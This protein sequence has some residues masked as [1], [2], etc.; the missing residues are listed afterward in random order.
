MAIFRQN[1]DGSVSTVRERDGAEVE[2]VGGSAGSS[3]TNA[4]SYLG[5]ATLAFNVG[6]GTDT[7][8]GLLSWQNSLGYDVI[9]QAFALDVLTIATSACTA[10]FGHSTTS[11][12]SVGQLI[13]G[14]DV[15]SSTGVFNSASAGPVKVPSLD[16]ITGSVGGGT[17]SGLVARAYFT[18]IPA[19][20]AGTA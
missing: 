17:S 14:K 15:H 16:Y 11:T 9:V 18:L 3:G 8:G 4:P 6:G 13:S 20:A 5:G 2:R 10:S 12:G 1:A 7:G 19:G